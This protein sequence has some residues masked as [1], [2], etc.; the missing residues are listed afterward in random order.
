MALRAIP[1]G[2]KLAAITLTVLVSAC[3]AFKDSSEGTTGFFQCKSPRPEMCTREYRPVCGHIDTR[4]ETPN[5]SKTHCASE[6]CPTDKH[7]TFGN[8][9]SACANP[10]VMGYEEGS[11]ES[12]GK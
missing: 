9:C 8:S 6:P 5:E 12:Y 1:L 4:I 3:S 7:Q 11:C 2:M 10:A